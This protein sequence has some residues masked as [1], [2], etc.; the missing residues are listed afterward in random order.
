MRTV[1]KEI[2]LSW[3][4]YRTIRFRY[5]GKPRTL[6]TGLTLHEAQ[7]H[8][9]RPDTSSHSTGPGA[10]FDGYDLMRGYRRSEG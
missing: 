8:C 3:P 2:P 4:V 10:W 1:P 5:N 9:K 6:R 7:D